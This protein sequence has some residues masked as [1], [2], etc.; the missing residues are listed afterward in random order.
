MESCLAEC[1]DHV[2]RIVFGTSQVQAEAWTSVILT[3]LAFHGFISVL[4]E[5]HRDNA[6]IKT[7]TA[8]LNITSN[9]SL[10]IRINRR[11]TI[12]ARAGIA[13]SV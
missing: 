2:V 6:F 9:S 12:V 4:Q 3:A 5:K 10:I 13:K 7:K 11:Y 8:L 1:C